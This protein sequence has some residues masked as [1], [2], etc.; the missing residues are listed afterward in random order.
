MAPEIVTIL[1]AV[2]PIFEVRGAIPL[3]IFSFGFSP[4]KA[5]ILSVLGNILP[6]IPL[7]LLLRFLSDYL[8]KRSYW[9]NRL[10]VK[11]FEYTR[12]RHE[13]KFDYHHHTHP[14]ARLEA[15]A[16]CLFVAIPLPF[17]G[18]WSATVAAIVFGIPLRR[19]FGAM[20]AGVILAGI[21][22]LILS[23]GLS[24]IFSS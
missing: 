22:M 1:T 15:I 14:R 4:E 21:I 23:L 6:I 8:A 3:G 13:S 18:V 11:L 12:N 9:V 5:Y 20:T 24:S 19:A 10:L 2:A 17:T 7:Y 16:L